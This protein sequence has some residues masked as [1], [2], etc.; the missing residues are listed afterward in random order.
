MESTQ[1]IVTDV[2]EGRARI[3]LRR[4]RPRAMTEDMDGGDRVGDCATVGGRN[5]WR[6]FYRL[7]CAPTASRV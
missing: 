7:V 3:S 6:R 5:S 1:G 4:S 2:S